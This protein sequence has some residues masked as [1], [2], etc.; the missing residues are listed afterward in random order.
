MV[1]T[2]LKE[3]TQIKNNT[4]QSICFDLIKTVRLHLTGLDAMTAYLFICNVDN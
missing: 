4:N 3:E 2:V 1:K